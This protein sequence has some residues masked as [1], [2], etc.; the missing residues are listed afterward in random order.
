[1]NWK[2]IEKL[3]KDTIFF[4]TIGPMEEHGPHLPVGTDFLIAKFVEKK[5]MTILEEKKFSV[6]S[7]PSLPIGCCRMARDFPGSMSIDWKAVRD[8]LH[9]IFVSA[10]KMNFRNIIV[11][12][13]HMDLHHIKAIHTA[14]EKGKKEGMTICEPFS[15]YYFKGML[16]PPLNGEGEVHADMKE[17]SLAL[18]LFP[19]LVKEWNDLPPVKIKM[20]GPDALFKTMKE[21]GAKEGYVGN[22]SIANE[23]YGKKFLEK[24]TDICT[25]T[26]MAMLS[27]E[28]LP[29]LPTRIKLLLRFIK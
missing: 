23:E 2:E 13:F 1:M 11:C 18:V 15:S 26:A 16:W 5:A 9:Q 25:E 29:E 12:N 22:P 6:V 7:L 10:A 21:M 8:M 27:G 4:L 14:I 28:E 3:D 24:I 19:E 20:D 17:T